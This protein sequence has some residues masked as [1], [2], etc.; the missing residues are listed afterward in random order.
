MTETFVETASLQDPIKINYVRPD[1]LLLDSENPRFAG[2]IGQTSDKEILQKLRKEMHL[3]ELIE[4]FQKNGYYNTEPLL[5]IRHPKQ[6]GKFIVI[7]GNRRLAAIRLLLTPEFKIEKKIAQ[8]LGNEIPIAV[9]PS[10]KSLW[11]YLGFRHINGA[12][13]WDSYSKAIYALRVH[14]EYKI[15]ITTIAAKIGDTHLTVVRMCN[16]LRVLEQAE[17]EELF[18]TEDIDLRRFYF[19]HLYTILQKQNT[20]KFL[21]IKEKRNDILKKNPVPKSKLRNLELL[22]KLLFG[23]PDGTVKP[24]VKSQNPDLKNLDEVFGNQQAFKYLKENSQEQSALE[25]ALAFTLKDDLVL[26]ELVYKTLNS[27]RKA[28][29][30]VYKYKGDREVLEQVKEM[31]IIIEGMIDSLSKKQK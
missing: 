13:E 10:R 14:N 18:S 12:K 20:Q 19:S 22:L 2:L 7:E 29:G 1:Q 30:I 9:Y 16:G 21:G 26:S 25:N 15:P 4:S 24:V 28:N 27:L 5:T 11:T 3:D 17:R 6:N 8:Q 23:T 31:K